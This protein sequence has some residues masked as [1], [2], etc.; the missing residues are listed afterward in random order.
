MQHM[1]KERAIEL[2]AMTLEVMSQRVRLVRHG[3]YADFGSHEVRILFQ[4]AN[5]ALRSLVITMRESAPEVRL[6]PL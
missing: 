5:G 2:A 4:Y 1:T 3:H 6:Q